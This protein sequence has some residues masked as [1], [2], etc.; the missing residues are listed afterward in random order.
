LFLRKREE[1]PIE[2]LLPNRVTEKK[3][4]K[5]NCSREISLLNNPWEK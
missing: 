4:K 2:V 5:G 1:I 3:R